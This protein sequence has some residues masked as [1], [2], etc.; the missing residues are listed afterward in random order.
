MSGVRVHRNS[1]KP[2]ALQAHAYAQGQD[3]HLGPGQEK[4][5]P[6]EAWHV[7]QQAQG[8]VR[9]TMQMKAGIPVNDDASL[10]READLMGRQA[11]SQLQG[12]SIGLP[13]PMAPSH[14]LV[15]RVLL[16]IDGV[17]H[18]AQVGQLL[19][20]ALAASNPHIQ[21]MSADPSFQVYITIERSE[22][23]GDGRTSVQWSAE[24][25]Q[26]FLLISLDMRRDEAASSLQAT[27]LHELIL[28]GI[29]AHNKHI[30]AAGGD[31][32]YTDPDSELFDLEEEA[33]HG[34]HAAWET[35]LGHSLHQGEA[36][37]VET[38][39]DLVRHLGVDDEFGLQVCYL[40]QAYDSDF[41]ELYL[42]EIT[43]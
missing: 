35:L 27:L 8:R 33:E 36:T 21:A 22:D 17:A 5:L 9:P 24:S 14:G 10:E 13:R 1:S 26:S 40:L 20:A 19:F 37:W 32:G 31:P 12:N 42:G 25:E 11:Q 23:G 4:H 41:A 43:D 6:H 15:Q 3:I 39:K 2:A 18:D 16:P 38:C 34:D 28:H 30:A 7:V 29:P